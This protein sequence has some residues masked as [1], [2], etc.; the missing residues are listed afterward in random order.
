MVQLTSISV[1]QACG[2]ISPHPADPDSSPS[3]DGVHSCQEC[4]A[5]LSRVV[6]DAALGNGVG[7]L[8]SPRSAKACGI[9][10]LLGQQFS[11]IA[12]LQLGAGAD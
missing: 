6:T 11:D 1:V 3:W 8:T 7:R 5:Q 4:C 12:E 2:G 10:G 9:L